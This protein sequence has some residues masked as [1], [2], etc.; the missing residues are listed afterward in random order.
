M[1]M[2]DVLKEIAI[3]PEIRDALLGRHNLLS[4]VFDL[5]VQY[6]KGSWEGI[7]EA[8]ARLGVSADA[9]AGAFVQAVDWAK[10]IL[11]GHTG[12]SP[13][14]AAPAKQGPAEA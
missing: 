12:E 2:E 4:E 10:G 8:A 14:S 13:E 3:R 9:L 5:A 11:T 1:K 7:E 6:E